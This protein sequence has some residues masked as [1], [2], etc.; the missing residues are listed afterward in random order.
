MTRTKGKNRHNCRSAQILRAHRHAISHARTHAHTHTSTHARTTKI[1]R[2][3]SARAQITLFLV[4]CWLGCP[5]PHTHTHTHINTHQNCAF[6]KHI[7]KYNPKTRYIYNL[8]P[9]ELEQNTYASTMPK[10]PKTKT[11][12][13]KQNSLSLNH[14]KQIK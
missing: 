12:N 7:I 3:T 10:K 14:C 8:S 4:L 5:A 6:V 13:S 2:R 9:Q 1:Y 11:K